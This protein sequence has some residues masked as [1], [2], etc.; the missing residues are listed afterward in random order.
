MRVR[1][2]LVLALRRERKEQ[3]MSDAGRANATRHTAHR[4]WIPVRERLPEQD[5]EYETLVKPLL[6]E[7]SYPVKQRYTRQAHPAISGF[8]H[9]PVTHWRPL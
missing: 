7:T 2:I 1:P 3:Q 5:G 8:Q 4:E 9:M 6:E